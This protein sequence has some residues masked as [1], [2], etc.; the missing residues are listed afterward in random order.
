MARNVQEVRHPL[1][2]DVCEFPYS[3]YRCRAHD[4][5]ISSGFTVS[6]EDGNRYVFYMNK[7]RYPDF[8]AMAAIYHRAGMKIAANVKPC[9][10]FHP[11]HQPC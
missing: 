6:E 10:P 1:L 2:S 8:K 9:T 5:Q 3:S 4:F 7:K 11:F